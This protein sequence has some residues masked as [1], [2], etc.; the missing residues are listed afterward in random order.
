MVFNKESKI[1]SRKDGCLDNLNFSIKP[2]ASF[3][4]SALL[5]YL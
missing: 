3:Q 5:A 1:S 4:L 2:Q